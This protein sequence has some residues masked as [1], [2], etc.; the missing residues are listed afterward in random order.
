MSWTHITGSSTH[1]AASIILGTCFALAAGN[2]KDILKGSEEGSAIYMGIQYAY[3]DILI[4]A[5]KEDLA[6]RNMI[7]AMSLV[8]LPWIQRWKMSFIDAISF[9]CVTFVIDSIIPKKIGDLMEDI[10][11]DIAC[12]LLICGMFSQES[13]SKDITPFAL[14]R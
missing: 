14:W 13:V 11:R 5:L 10:P 7:A 3:S 8:L 1:I 2:L 4:G 12:L 6:A 9:T